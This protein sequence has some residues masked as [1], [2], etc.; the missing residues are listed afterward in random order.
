MRAGQWKVLFSLPSPVS[1][2]RPRSHERGNRHSRADMNADHILAPL[3]LP[4]QLKPNTFPS[5]I[6]VVDDDAEFRDI[7][8]EVLQGA[9]HRVSCAEDGESG[10]DAFCADRFDVVIIDHDMPRLTGLDLLRRVRPGSPALPVVLMS[11]GMPWDEAD[12]LRLLTP[13]TALEKPFS[14]VELLATVRGLLASPTRMGDMWQRAIASL[15][16]SQSTANSGR[17]G[18]GVA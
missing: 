17:T 15:A 8:A 6:L 4:E 7:L 12:F 13:G 9:G 18:G 5:H 3:M 16:R 1:A 14:S 10:W 11:G 2:F